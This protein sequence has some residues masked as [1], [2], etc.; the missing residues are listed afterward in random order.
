MQAFAQCVQES[1]QLCAAVITVV[2]VATCV[3]ALAVQIPYL[4]YA[5][6]RRHRNV[7]AAAVK[8]WLCLWLRL[9]DYKRRMGE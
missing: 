7:C 2:I 4:S 3:V 9:P 8:V 6:V 5:R 1:F